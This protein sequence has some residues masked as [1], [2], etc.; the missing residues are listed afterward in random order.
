[1]ELALEEDVGGC[2]RHGEKGRSVGEPVKIWARAEAGHG[3]VPVLARV[4]EV[5]FANV[6]S[7]AAVVVAR[8]RE[9]SGGYA[10]PNGDLGG[11]VCVFLKRMLDYGSGERG[12]CS[13]AKE[14]KA[15][16]KARVCKKVKRGGSIGVGS[17]DVDA[18]G[19]ED[20]KRFSYGVNH[21]ESFIERDGG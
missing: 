8:K 11:R 13:C 4:V 10:N 3:V 18:G 17:V 15:K 12:V 7:I 16:R 14:V 2:E 5:E 9:R 6:K 20:G 1:M 21:V 19:G